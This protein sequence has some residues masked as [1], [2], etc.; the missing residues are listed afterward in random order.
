[1]RPWRWLR[2]NWPQAV[3]HAI[4][5]F[6]LGFWTWVLTG[7][8]VPWYIAVMAM[9]L[10]SVHGFLSGRLIGYHQ[11]GEQAA[12]I[13]RKGMEQQHA[14]Y[15]KAN[16]QVMDD[17]VANTPTELGERYTHLVSHRDRG[18]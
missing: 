4:D 18:N 1:M 3:G 8:G 15:L 7:W 12:A 16:Q 14:I 11:A 5:L 10:G 17:L 9:V 2:P 13:W 6:V